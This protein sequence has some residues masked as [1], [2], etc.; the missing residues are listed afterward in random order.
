[1]P[2]PA[3]RLSFSLRP[4]PGDKH[5]RGDSMD[6]PRRILASI[7]FA[8]ALVWQG[9]VGGELRKVARGPYP[10]APA[11]RVCDAPGSNFYPDYRP[12]R[13]PPYGQVTPAPAY[14][15][16]YFGARSKP[17]NVV[18]RGYFGDFSRRIYPRG[19]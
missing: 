10:S 7:L 2:V 11:G 12:S 6:C 16:G 13:Y 9:A 17:Y 15:W 8:M 3:Y 4:L 18:H 14:A 5:S 19:F 1:M